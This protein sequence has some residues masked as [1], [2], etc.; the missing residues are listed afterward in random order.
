MERVVNIAKEQ[1]EAN[2]WDV[3][4]AISM[5]VEERQEAALTLKQ[6]VYGK[7]PDLK[8]WRKLDEE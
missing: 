8:A 2:K 1:D 4:Q 5:S 3:K 6:R 7:Q